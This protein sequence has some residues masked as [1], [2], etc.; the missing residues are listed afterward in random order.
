MN[1]Y[2]GHALDEITF[3]GTFQ[4]ARQAAIMAS[5]TGSR[6]LTE[7]HD[8]RLADGT[9]KTISSISVEA[10][11]QING[12]LN[13]RYGVR[14]WGPAYRV[15]DVAVVIVLAGSA[16]RYHSHARKEV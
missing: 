8:R 5:C 7:I 9:L 1:M 14:S 11:D 2:Q 15:K 4:E 6:G 12:D 10:I 3:D 13:R 16:G